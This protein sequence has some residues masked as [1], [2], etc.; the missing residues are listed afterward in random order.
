MWG[1]NL[2]PFI[3]QGGVGLFWPGFCIVS[4]DYH[5]VSHPALFWGA[6]QGSASAQRLV[7]GFCV[8]DFMCLIGFSLFLEPI[9]LEVCFTSRATV[10]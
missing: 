5:R 6:Y 4:L 9:M 7:S 8:R 2:I 10:S 1:E 3:I